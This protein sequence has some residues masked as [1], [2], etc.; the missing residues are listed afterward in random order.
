MHLT[1]KFLDAVAMGEDRSSSPLTFIWPMPGNVGGQ[2]LSFSA[3]AEWQ[4]FV[5]DLGLRRSVPDIVAADI[6]QG[7]ID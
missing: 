7:L 5:L 6:E 2:L 1:M 4:A 3:F